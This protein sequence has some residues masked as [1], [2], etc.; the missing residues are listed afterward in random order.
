MLHMP[1]AAALAKRCPQC[2]RLLSADSLRCG[3][4]LAEVWDV[5]ADIEVGPAPGEQSRS[6]ASRRAPRLRA[7]ADRTLA[8]PKWRLGL[9]VLF[10]AA[11]GWYGFQSLK[12]ERTLASPSSAA[13]TLPAASTIW[14]TSGGNAGHTRHIA[15]APALN[16]MAV[17]WQSDLGVGV[18]A[19]PVADEARLYI[20]TV[21]NRIVA[22]DVQDGGL[23]WI[24]EESVPISGTPIVVDGR[25]Y[26][27]T[28][29]G[30]AVCLDAAT[31]IKIWSADLDANFFNS[32]TLA[33]GVLFAYGTA[34][35]LYGIDSEDGRLLWSFNTGSQWATLGPVVSGPWI[36]IATDDSVKVFDRESGGL[37][38]DH[39]QS[40][41]A[42]FALDEGRIFSVSPNFISKVDA[43]ARL[44]RWWGV[45]GIWLQMWVWG[46][47]PEPP[48]FGLDWL[49]A[50]RPQ[51]LALREPN[52]EV[53][54]PA[55][56]S[57]LVVVAN[58]HGLVRTF[59]TG[60]GAV[61]WSIEAG[62]VTGAP[63]WTAA[64]VLL[65]L[66]DALSMRSSTDGSEVARSPLPVASSR[67]VILTG[68]GVFLADTE[69][70]VIA[71]R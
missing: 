25:A 71:I 22:L 49:T 37:R 60:S 42:G 48:R 57:G 36:V 64:G 4:C 8:L 33:E 41:L 14:A 35:R 40:S 12:P 53:F 59:D 54:A 50:L 30:E 62:D 43:S 63:V 19:S 16:D 69:G 32:P 2:G 66:R 65:P 46:L 61:R 15:L 29:G 1:D 13:R 28:R 6:P 10:V 51:G 67:S 34:E 55:V 23:A 11:A 5:Q 52:P 58:E 17:A 20:P 45:R 70:R 27:L 56:A 24:Y 9:L 47:A 21:D 7:L 3:Y 39:P 68:Q 38:L 26:F 44:P 31:G 18:A